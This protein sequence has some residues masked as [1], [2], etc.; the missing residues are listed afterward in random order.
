M[1]GLDAGSGEEIRRDTV[2]SEREVSELGGDSLGE[3]WGAC[4]SG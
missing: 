2:E 1:W 3:T 4:L